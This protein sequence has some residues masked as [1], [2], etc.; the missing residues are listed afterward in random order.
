MNEAILESMQLVL[1]AAYDSPLVVRTYVCVGFV[2]QD[3]NKPIMP[4]FFDTKATPR[5]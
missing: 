2:N 4:F 1:G 5:Y 3:E